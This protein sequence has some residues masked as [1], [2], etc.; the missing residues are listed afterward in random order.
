LFAIAKG[1]PLLRLHRVRSVAGAPILHSCIALV[2]SRV[3]GFPRQPAKVPALI[4]RHILEAYGI[5]VAAVREKIRAEL[6]SAEDCR[7]LE[8][9]SPNAVL[10][11]DEDT[12]GALVIRSQH[13]ANT[14]HHYYANETR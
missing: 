13:P 1:E 14:A 7:L 12:T 11:I 5:R 6:A 4:Y 3:P 9:S 8:L 2:A 10:V